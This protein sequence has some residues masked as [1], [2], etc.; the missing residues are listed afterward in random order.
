M[1]VVEASPVVAYWKA[2]QATTT[3]SARMP[4]FGATE[5]SRCL[6]C[7]LG[8]HKGASDCAVRVHKGGG[9]W[10]ALEVCKVSGAAQWTHRFAAHVKDFLLA[11]APGL[12]CRAAA[13]VAAAI[14]AGQVS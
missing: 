7:F 4:N 10:T 3:E 8:T 9:L 14:L 2:A 1:A 6:R 11:A 5:L 12:C 13:A